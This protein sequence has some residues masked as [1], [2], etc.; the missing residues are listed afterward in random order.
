MMETA[1]DRTGTFRD[2]SQMADLVWAQGYYW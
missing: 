2:T 1:A